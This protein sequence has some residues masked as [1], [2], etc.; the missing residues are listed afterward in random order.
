MST[1]AREF[2][3]EMP[4]DLVWERISD[5]GAV[6]QLIDFLGEVRVDGRHRTCALG[7]AGQ[8]DEL[9]VTVDPD[10]R[11]L[12]YSIRKSPFD[13]EHHSASWHALADG[14]GGTRFVWITDFTPEQIAPALEQAIDDAVV[15][16]K[17]SLS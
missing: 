9:I 13:L 15:S 4:P 3:L 7:D 12:V 1:I 17:R 14:N 11:R 6:N 2:Q 8:L 10:E 5:V 16:M